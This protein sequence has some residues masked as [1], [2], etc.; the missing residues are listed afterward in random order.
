MCVFTFTI[1]MGF[2]D[3]WK[4]VYSRK[5]RTKVNALYLHTGDTRGQC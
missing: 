2:L 1:L 5:V 4:Q 3:R